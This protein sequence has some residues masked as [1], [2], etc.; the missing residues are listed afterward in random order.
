MSVIGPGVSAFGSGK[1]GGREATYEGPVDWSATT[2]FGEDSWDGYVVIQAKQR[3][4]PGDPHNNAVWLKGQINDEFDQ[5]MESNKRGKFP[6]YIVFVTNV[7]LSSVPTVGGIDALDEEIRSRVYR[8]PDDGLGKSISD[9]GLRGWKVWHRDQINGLLT[10]YSGVRDAFPGM[11]TAG[12]ILSRMGSISSIP[13]PSDLQ[14]VLHAHAWNAISSERWVNF[15]EAGGNN[16]LSVENVIVDLRIDGPGVREE[17]A[18]RE[19]ISRGEQSLRSSMRSNQKA[20]HVVLT[21]QPG[22]GKSTL[23]RFLTQVYRVKFIKIP[24]CSFSLLSIR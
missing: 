24:A 3:E 20:R 23:S 18:L 19:V 16:R 15:N 4:H 21:G 10:A 7:R 17:T 5:W 11:L 6:E 12:D 14:P 13:N 22:N 1:D 8:K 9:R 2:G